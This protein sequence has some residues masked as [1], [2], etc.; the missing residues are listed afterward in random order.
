MLAIVLP[1]SASGDLAEIWEFIAADNP[2]QADAFIDLI[3]ANFQNLSRHPDAGRRRDKLLGGLRSL[4]VERCL[5]FHLQDD[6]CLRIVRVFHGARDVEDVFAD[7]TE[8]N[9]P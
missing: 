3:D 5:I 1:P 4:P 7:P 8:E 6:V 9:Q 2:A